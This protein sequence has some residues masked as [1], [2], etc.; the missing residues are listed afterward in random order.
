MANFLKSKRKF[1]R[2]RSA[3]VAE[4]SELV[5]FMLK[6]ALCIAIPFYAI[7]LFIAV[8]Q[9]LWGTIVFIT[10]GLILLASAHLLKDLSYKLRGSVLIA[11]GLAI[12]AQDLFQ[13]G[14]NGS[15]LLYL[16]TTVFAAAL[17]YNVQAGV[18]IIV[19]A[20]G[21]LAFFGFAIATGTLD[22]AER[23]AHLVNSP[24]AWAL[25]IVEIIFLGGL[26]LISLYRLLNKLDLSV[27]SNQKLARRAEDN[28]QR[29]N[30]IVGAIPGS[31]LICCL[32]EK[33]EVLWANPL[34]AETFNIDSHALQNEA[35]H[36]R[37]SA[38][39]DD[40]KTI[41]SQVANKHPIANHELRLRVAS[42]ETLWFRL[43]AR[44]FNY[45]NQDAVLL[46]L[47][48]IQDLREAQQ[49]LQHLER[50]ETLG[51]MAGGIAHDF[52]NLLVGMLAQNGLALRIV[53]EDSKAARHITKA[54]SA[55][56]RASEVTKQ[57]LAYSGHAKFNL[58][59]F[60][61]NA[62]I[63]D[64]LPKLVE[65]AG[66]K[67]TVISDLNPA[68]LRISADKVQFQQLLFNLVEN[69]AEAEAT[70]IRIITNNVFFDPVEERSNR[71]TGQKLDA[72][73]YIS[74]QIIDNGVGMSSATEA[75]MFDPFFSTKDQGHGLGLA[76]V[77]GIVRGHAGAIEIDTS[78]GEG[79]TITLYVPALVPD[80]SNLD[81]WEDAIRNSFE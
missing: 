5:S 50:V 17:I 16:L 77:L 79:T 25:R 43:T 37:F 14:F 54:V 26:I 78:I 49:T 11:I 64:Q 18:A 10:L 69:A 56:E 57:L 38:Q 23:A 52:N 48:D 22:Y 7:T 68:V 75:A 65:C 47:D 45:S 81:I 51:L 72:T 31:V 36:S 71:I 19:I 53:G 9:Q 73:H 63:E 6:L 41:L 20:T 35:F 1:Q 33:L 3:L 59:T 28:R 24:L 62:L 67:C 60:K 30:E 42:K 21:V 44:N 80:T 12:A 2:E 46:I 61:L 29:L 34:A 4:Q 55:A 74:M 15:G 70:E 8:Q 32:S 40:L 13:H 76:A 66:P 27:V 39:T 58:A